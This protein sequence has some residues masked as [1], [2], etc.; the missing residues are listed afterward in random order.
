MKNLALI[1]LLALSPTLV[2]QT[3][4]RKDTT[5]LTK[6]S[7]MFNEK[8]DYSLKPDYTSISGE[9]S[10]PA[11][12]PLKTK[13][14]ESVDLR[15]PPLDVYLGP[16]LENN[17]FTRYPFAND[18]SFASG[19]SISDRAWLT[20]SSSQYGYPTLGAIRSVGVNF[21]YMPTDWLTIGA[22]PYGSKYNFY[23][24]NNNDVGVNGSLKFRLTDRISINGYGQ[25]SVFAD[26]NKVYG[27]LVNMYPSTYYGGTVEFKITEKFG[28]E[29]GVIREL[30]PF[31]G[32][33]VNRPYIA[34]VFYAK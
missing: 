26:K 15:L 32:K 5:R 25:Y 30:D 17:T 12:E 1:L 18:Y 6:E 23:G 22:G 2:A 29:G 16:P 28:V 8:T 14:T 10:A 9:F 24:I 20:S 4:A 11:F 33:W 21:N 7:L 34:P 13:N 19:M 31:S 27:P 3:E